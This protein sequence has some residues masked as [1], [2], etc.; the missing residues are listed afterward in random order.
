MTPQQLAEQAL[1]AIDPSTVV[2]TDQARRVAGRD[3][4]DLVLTPRDT[5]SRVGSVRIAID[6]Q[7]KIPLA[8]QVYA[9]GT[10][11]AAIDVS[12][13]SIDFSVPADSEFAFT[14]PKTAIVKQQS[15]DAITGSR[16]KSGTAGGSG[17]A[18]SADDHGMRII[19]TGWTSVLEVPGSGPIQSSPSSP[20]SVQSILNALAPVSGTW[21]SGRLFDSKLV[22]ALITDDGRIFIGMV[23][24][25]VLYA[26]A[27]ASK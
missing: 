20:A 13:T 3:A 23:E 2:T 17:T 12:F 7:H 18:T 25:S 27:A 10:T 6:S 15:L 4:Y 21:G 16:D 26:A 14:P 22:T 1:A 24:P 8:V 5:T 9:R 11:S 19:G